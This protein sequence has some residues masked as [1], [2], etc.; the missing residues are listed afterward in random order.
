MGREPDR[1]SPVTCQVRCTAQ[2]GSSA[3][4]RMSTV[5]VPASQTDTRTRHT[6]QIKASSSRSGDLRL[7]HTTPGRLDGF[8][9]ASRRLRCVIVPRRGLV[10]RDAARVVGCSPPEHADPPRAPHLEAHGQA[11][12][13]AVA[14][15]SSRSWPSSWSAPSRSPLDVPTT[16]RACRP[17]QRPL[18]RRKPSRA[19]PPGVRGQ[20]EE[21]PETGVGFFAKL[22]RALGLSPA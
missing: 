15:P 3:N 21:V 4:R 10:I 2:K 5:S 7:R 9:N 22:G 13:H 11:R 16:T 12:R 18:P 17:P 14:G 19:R 20:V 1:L 6:D 8:R